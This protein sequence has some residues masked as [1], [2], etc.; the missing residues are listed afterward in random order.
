MTY[1]EESI[2]H[3]VGS[4]CECHPYCG[5]PCARCDYMDIIQSN[6]YCLDALIKLHDKGKIKISELGNVS[7]PEFEINDEKTTT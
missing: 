2:L 6:K 3:I 5:S 1:L 7:Y 4:S